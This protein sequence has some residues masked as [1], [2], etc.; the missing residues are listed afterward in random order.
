MKKEFLGKLK[1]VKIDTEIEEIIVFFNVFEIRPTR[2]PLICCFKKIDSD[3]NKENV[4][5]CI[6][7]PLGIFTENFD[8]GIN[9]L[10]KSIGKIVKITLLEENGKVAACIGEL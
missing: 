10:R 7:K 4:K 1:C 3:K 8:D 6:F 2:S 5:N 9:Y